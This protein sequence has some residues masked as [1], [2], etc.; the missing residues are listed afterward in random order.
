MPLQFW[1]IFWLLCSA[2]GR[3][4]KY[5]TAVTLSRQKFYV[6]SVSSKFIIWKLFM[7]FILAFEPVVFIV[8]HVY[9]ISQHRYEH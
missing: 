2:P 1:S 9:N 8:S 7:N 5:V 3:M 6:H 4:T